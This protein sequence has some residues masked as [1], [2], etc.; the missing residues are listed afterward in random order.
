ML[1]VVFCAEK[2]GKM[3]DQK[4]LDDWPN[5]YNSSHN[6]GFWCR[7]SFELSQY[8]ITQQD[9]L[10]TINN[11]KLIFIIFINFKYLKIINF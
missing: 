1:R 7:N 10:I 11:V 4:Y 8:K 2:E 6:S 9:K 3:G 5:K